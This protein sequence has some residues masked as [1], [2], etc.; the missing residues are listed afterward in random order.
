VVYGNCQA[1]WA[2]A[3]VGADRPDVCG[4]IILN[5]APMSYW[6]GE[7]GANPMRASGGLLGGDWSARLISDLGAGKFDGAWLVHNFEQLNPAR[8]YFKKIYDLYR[9]IDTGEK[10]FLDFEQWW[11]GFY[12]MTEAEIIWIIQNLFIGNCLEQGK[13]R[14]SENH[15]IDLRQ[16]KDP[17]VVFA[18]GGD[19]ITPPAQALNWIAE[20]YPTT[21]ELKKH[22]QRIVYLLN[23]H[24]GHLGIF[25]SAKVA[26]REHRAMIENLQRF[27]ELKPGLYQMIIVRETG[28]EDPK[29]DQFEV[30]FEERRVED[31]DFPV[32]REAFSRVDAVSRRLD[33]LYRQFV[34]PWV[35]PLVNPAVAETIKWMHPD[36]ISRILYSERLNPWMLPFAALAALVKS[37]RRPAE[38]ENPF[39]GAE[40]RAAENTV[41]LMDAWRDLRDNWY[42]TMFRMFFTQE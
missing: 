33:E 21:A 12:Q 9:G 8:T 41:A 16:A 18:S 23:P 4:P 37:R 2:V 1:G 24:A 32:D 40:R 19:D 6:A 14:L 15:Q 5:G 38:N 26:R 30:R 10:R 42:E 22:G 31:V 25:V 29:K 34:R 17:I 7:A 11:T 13:L 35:R 27:P 28:E 3:M 36:R 20:V 39:I